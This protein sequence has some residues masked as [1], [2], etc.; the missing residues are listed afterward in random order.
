MILGIFFLQTERVVAQDGFAD[1]EISIF[2]VTPD[3]ST[4]EFSLSIRRNTN[5]WERF[6]NGTFQF[7]MDRI[8]L[9]Q[10][11]AEER[12][13]MSDYDSTSIRFE[14]VSAFEDAIIQTTDF[15]ANNIA[16]ISSY[17]L[18][19]QVIKRADQ[20]TRLSIAYQGPPEFASNQ[21]IPLSSLDADNSVIL[22]RFRIT[23]LDGFFP[24]ME[25]RWKD[26]KTNFGNFKYLS[27]AYKLPENRN[28]NGV[29]NFYIG[30]DN[31]DF[32]K[33]PINL[34]TIYKND[35]SNL[36]TLLS[37]FTARYIGGQVVRLQWR[38]RQ[39]YR[40]A[41]FRIYRGF[42]LP[43]E[44]ADAIEFGAEPVVVQMKTLG[45][46]ITN[47]VPVEYSA[48]DDSIPENR[49]GWDVCY[50]IEWSFMQTDTDSI[51]KDR[52]D[53]GEIGIACTGVPNAVISYAHAY[54]NPFRVNTNVEY[55]VEDDVFLTIKLYDVAGRVIQVYMEDQFVQKGTYFMDTYLPETASN[56]MMN[57]IFYAD[58][59]NDVSVEKSNAVLKLQKLR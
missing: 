21:I 37:S 14:Q 53:D 52:F 44:D 41:G 7:E 22:G 10:T 11:G 57:L 19:T 26:D 54:P 9:G 29:S 20:P 33:P 15:T 30:D 45:S 58:P 46:S 12:V 24:R 18:K 3:L 38:T 4:F 48:L 17:V 32:G 34:I 50:K 40:T 43:F 31:I 1:A 39:E 55:T 42:K 27:T 28:I 25:I 2:D 13:P 23:N 59:I 35:T 8:I 47:K 16:A 56:G 5:A 6:V 36:R 49:R 51:W